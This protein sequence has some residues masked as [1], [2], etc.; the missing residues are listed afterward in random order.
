M[1]YLYGLIALACIIAWLDVSSILLRIA[2]A[3]EAMIPSEVEEDDDD[4]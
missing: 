3:L 1:Y 2:L 4:E